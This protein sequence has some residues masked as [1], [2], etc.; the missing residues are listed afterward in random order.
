MKKYERIM[1]YLDELLKKNKEKVLNISWKNLRKLRRFKDIGDRTLI[2]IVKEYKRNH[3]D[4]FPFEAEL[5]PLKKEIVET[6]LEKLYSKDPEKFDHMSAKDLMGKAEL[7][8]IGKTT[9][10][11]SL[12]EFR[13]N[14]NVFKKRKTGPDTKPEIAEN[15][16]F[17]KKDK[18]EEYLT[19]LMSAI[20]ISA[21][22]DLKPKDVFKAPDLKNISKATISESLKRFKKRFFVGIAIDHL[23][24]EY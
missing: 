20:S 2:D 21:L 13:K 1:N 18:V 22:Y 9:I 23:E 16:V 24:E 17:L 14:N 19:K 7:H 8:G 5:K 12:S 4:L 10:V 6:C 11:C 3:D 15:G